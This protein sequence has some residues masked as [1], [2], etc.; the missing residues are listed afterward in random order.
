MPEVAERL[1][2]LD[3][4]DDESRAQLLHRYGHA[5]IDVL[6]LA[7]ESPAL[8]ERITPE[9]PDL[10]AEAPFAARREQAVALA[11]VLLRR[12]RLGLTAASTICRPGDPAPERA[13]RAMGA[14]LGWDDAR[15]ASE[16]E[17]WHEVAREEGLALGAG[18]SA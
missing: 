1:P 9:R 4:V 3:A 13:A 2:A 5:A 10:V 18:V 7:S 14:E 12:T 8:A 16:V 11:D 6:K 15:V 17:A